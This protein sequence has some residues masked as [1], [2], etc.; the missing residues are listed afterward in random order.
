MG[1]GVW[2]HVGSPWGGGGLSTRFNTVFK[3]VVSSCLENL[4]DTKATDQG[5]G[6]IL[7]GRVVS[8]NSNDDRV[9]G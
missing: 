9:M 1:G 8:F 7:W 5:L 2:L 4:C 3:K 6:Y